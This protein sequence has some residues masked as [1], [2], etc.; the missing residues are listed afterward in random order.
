M[1]QAGDALPAYY[2]QR[3]H[4]V[5]PFIYAVERV[6][7]AQIAAG[8]NADR[9]PLKGKI[10]RI[11]CVSATSADALVIDYKTGRA[12]SLGEIRGGLEEGEVSKTSEGSIFRQMAFYALLLEE[13]EPFLV[14]QAFSVEF[15]GERGE[16]PATRQ[17]AVTEKEKEDLRRL[18]RA[19]WEKITTL[20][21]TP[22]SNQAIPVTSQKK[23]PTG[24]SH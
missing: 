7:R 15:I 24:A 4:G 23:H 13:A 22:L 12:K 2:K 14:P 21:F 9:I 18:I 17:F 8:R 19:V 1:S 20:D 10:D 16:D 11:D 3:L 6:Y 5:Q